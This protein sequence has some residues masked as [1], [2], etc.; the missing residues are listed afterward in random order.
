MGAGQKGR[1]DAIKKWAENNPEFAKASKKASAC[2]WR[3][4][5]R[6]KV[7][8][9]AR[10]NRNGENLLSDIREK[11]CE[12]MKDDPESL[13]SGFV[14]AILELDNNDYEALLEMDKS[15]ENE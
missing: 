12:D 7:N 2:R 3:A 6:S 13:S 11:H 14:D 5:N 9:Q 1:R 15:D 8:K 4:K 10:D